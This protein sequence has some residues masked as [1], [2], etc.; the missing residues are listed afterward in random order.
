MWFTRDNRS[1]LNQQPGPKMVPGIILLGVLSYDN[2]RRPVFWGASRYR[3]TLT[4][5]LEVPVVARGGS[6]ESTPVF[7]SL[8]VLIYQL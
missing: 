4:F 2:H 3:L 8:S 6:E 7:K 1:Y 5:D